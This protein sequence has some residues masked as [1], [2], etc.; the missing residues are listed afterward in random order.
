MLSCDK[1]D[2]L[3]VKWS[4]FYLQIQPYEKK[5]LY[6]CH[7]SFPMPSKDI[8]IYTDK[9]E[10]RVGMIDDFEYIYYLPLEIREAIKA[11]STFSVQALG[12]AFRPTPQAS[13]PWL[14]SRKFSIA[15]KS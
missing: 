7:T 1:F 5:C 14:T 12:S 13:N 9:K 6:I 10:Y 4:T 8:K 11:A 3:V 2:G 15:T